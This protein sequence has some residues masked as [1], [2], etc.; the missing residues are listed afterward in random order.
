MWYIV[1]LLFVIY[2]FFYLWYIVSLLFVIYCFFYLRYIVSSIC[3][4]C[5]SSICDILFI[6][7]VIYCY[8]FLWCIN[9]ASEI[10]LVPVVI[11]FDVLSLVFLDMEKKYLARGSNQQPLDYK[12]DA[13]PIKQTRRKPFLIYW[14]WYICTWDIHLYIKCSICDIFISGIILRDG[15]ASLACLYSV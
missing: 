4:Y 10:L 8:F 14:L 2:C 7:F 11:L 9:C 1:S 13:L 3:E 12:S 6:L 15:R 5:F